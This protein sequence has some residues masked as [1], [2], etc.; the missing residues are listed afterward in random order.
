MAKVASFFLF[1]R[2]FF[3]TLQPIK[4]IIKNEKDYL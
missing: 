2:H 4:T 3:I 1:Y